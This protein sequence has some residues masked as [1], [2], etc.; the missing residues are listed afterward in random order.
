MTNKSIKKLEK[1]SLWK[2]A[3]WKAIF[4]CILFFLL[5][6]QQITNVVRDNIEN[7]ALDIIY[8]LSFSNKDQEVKSTDSRVSVFAYDNA[9]MRKEGLYIKDVTK[10][11]SAKKQSLDNINYGYIFPRERLA[12]FLNALDER[13]KDGTSCPKAVF[14]DF[15]LSFPIATF[16]DEKGKKQFTD[17]DK[18]LLK[19]LKAEHCYPILLPKMGIRH[20]IE[21]S[22]DQRLR[23]LIDK[24]QKIIF[25]SPYFH[26]N[27]DA[28]VRRYKPTMKIGAKE[29]PSAAHA[30]WKLMNNK[31]I[32][33]EQIK[34]DF[35]DYVQA[36][37]EHSKSKKPTVN[38]TYIWLKTYDTD[39]SEI[40][41]D[42]C[43]P[44]SS[45]WKNL[46]KYSLTESLESRIDSTFENAV[47][48]LG[49][50]FQPDTTYHRGM[51]DYH[52]VLNFL[53]NDSFSGVDIHANILMTLLH[54]DQDEPMQ[55]VPTWLS[56]IIIFISFFL[57]DL[58]VSVFFQLIGKS[59]EKVELAITLIINII[60]LYLVSRFFLTRTPPLWFNWFI[61]WILIELVEVIVIAR[62]HLPQWLIKMRKTT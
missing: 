51:S 59:N 31:P 22:K 53:G 57:V 30:L 54:F 10:T 45:H 47:I 32:D 8:K 28:Q 58:L 13:L 15:D 49:G 35:P 25:V 3:L 36:D 1:K 60:L 2:E 42:A 43:T 46:K 40:K 48:L 27:K 56:L 38:G 29:Y 9:Y 50:T 44:C 17:G 5:D 7:P 18:A 11:A 21:E 52:S 23:E 33:P 55:A 14:I 41:G 37:Q 4:A 39:I 12:H 19:A 34:K 16:I 24:Q 6:S 20:F 62:K 61:P 26:D